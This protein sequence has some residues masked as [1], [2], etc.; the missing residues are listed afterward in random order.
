MRSPSLSPIPWGTHPWRSRFSTGRSSRP[1]KHASFLPLPQ[2]AL[3]QQRLML[4]WLLAWALLST[5]PA[6][7]TN[8]GL[9]G[10]WS[11]DDGESGLVSDAARGSAAG[12]VHGADTIPGKRGRALQFDGVDDYVALGD[13]GT[14]PAV[15]IAFWMRL[16]PGG[17]PDDFQGLVTSDT[18]GRG[19]LHVPLR[20]RQVDV[21]LHTGGGSRARVSSPPLRHATWYHVGLIADARSGAITLFIN[22]MRTDSDT[23]HPGLAHIRLPRQVIGR[24]ME[25][26]HFAGAIDDV[27]I[28]GRTL[29]DTEI[30]ALCPAMHPP[31]R[32]DP[33]DIRNGLKIPDEGYCDQPYVVVTNDGKW[34]CTLTTG[35]GHEG[36]AGQ[37]VVSA[38]SSD[39]GQTWSPLVDIEPSNGPNASWAVPLIVPSGRIYAFYTFNG[40]EVT[41]LPGSTKRVRS[42]THGWYC[43]RYTDDNGQTWSP[44][45]YRIPMRNTACDRDNTFGGRVQMFWGIDKPKIADGSVYFAITKLAR[46]FL[47]NGEGWLYRSA[48]LL[49]QPNP[50]LLTFELL[51]AG[52]HGIRN[53]TFGSV[54]EEHNVV[55]LGDSSLFCVYRTTRGHP[56]QSTSGDSGR[57]WSVPEPMTYTPGGRTFKQPRACPKL[58]RTA[59]GHY[60]FWYH[61]HGGTS[62]RGRNPVWITG[63]TARDGAIHWSQPEILLFAD[64][65]ATR[66]SY[67]DLIEQAG[68]FWVTETQKSEAR[69]HEIAPQLLEGL[70]AQGTNRTPV[71][72]GR[73]VCW[74]EAEPERGKQAAEEDVNVLSGGGLSLDLL[75]Q[76]TEEQ[77][78][79]RT[80]AEFRGTDG[81]TFSLRTARTGA[82]QLDISSGSRHKTW[83]TETGVLRSGHPNHVVVI[84]DAAPR[85]ILFVVNGVLLDGGPEQQCGWF[86]CPP[87]YLPTGDAISQPALHRVPASGVTRLWL[88]NR[89][90][91]VSEAVANHTAWKH[92]Q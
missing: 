70:W 54:Q 65:L 15:T 76:Q 74:S 29:T 28:Y 63:G 35:P 19:C 30:R 37:H 39:H 91:R 62:F 79:K 80:L 6:N 50:D 49:T 89:A 72:A 18:W 68:R 22:G 10:H 9:I 67:P 40:D 25:K 2:P 81:Y 21:F 11:L 48:N 3:P 44:R 88:Y 53:P 20:R 77:E 38:T 7:A 5:L 12:P 16:E 73:I 13:L 75:F 31:P 83:T 46:Y 36:Q 52:D 34:L 26:R 33:R 47:G 82:L 90:L 41:Q 60:L 86:R 92:S 56:C 85:L 55:P 4:M 45:R 27:R 23:F 71:A 17:N 51:P 32:K 8:D 66:M 69:V 24:E 57:T 64:N 42:D 58:W 78:D 1:R 61:N 87:D 84:L 14:H 59:N 43:F